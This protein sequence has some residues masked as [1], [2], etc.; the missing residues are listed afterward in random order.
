MNFMR[1]I[2]LGILSSLTV[3]AATPGVAQ[4][5]AKSIPQFVPASSWTVKPA[6]TGESRQFKNLKLPCMMMAEYDNGYILRLSGGQNN[7]MAMAVDFRQEAFVQGRKYTTNITVNGQ[8]LGQ[9]EATAFS[10]NAL[11]INTRNVGNFYQSLN[12]ASQM[13]LDVEGN[14]FQFSL[15]SIQGA[16]ALLESCYSG[17]PVTTQAKGSPLGAMPPAQGQEVSIPMA[18][19]PVGKALSNGITW[20]DTRSNISRA[21]SDIAMPKAQPRREKPAQ[22]WRARSGDSLKATLTRWANDANVDIDWQADMNG[23]VVSDMASTGSF[24]QA[25]QALIAQNAAATGIQA[26]LRGGDMGYAQ[27]AAPQAVSRMPTPLIPASSSG[28]R[29]MR[30]QSSVSQAGLSN[31][32][33]SNRGSSAS[34]S[35]WQANQGSNLRVALKNWSKRAGVELHWQA[36]QS[37]AVRQTVA[38]GGTYESALEAI[39]GQYMND[40]V[41][42]IAQL[43]NDPVSGRRILI[44]QS[45]RVL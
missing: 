16:M 22:M 6:V 41:R 2:S 39:L 25:V 4:V 14:A 24:E 18:D 40:S 37:F 32:S 26:D 19:K 34:A 1:K 7:I 38:N 3:L 8:K 29:Q 12:A 28:N 43:N 30:S 35:T 17:K 21:P 13:T 45:S 31:A 42:P 9:V 27:N 11:V 20:N 23:E 44:I 15:G 33:V 36:N 10:K 5:A